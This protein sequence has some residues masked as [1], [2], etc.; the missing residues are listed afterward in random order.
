MW[1]LERGYFTARAAPPCRIYTMPPMSPRRGVPAGH[2]A[3]AAEQLKTSCGRRS[4]CAPARPFQAPS[5]AVPRQISECATKQRVTYT[6][7]YHC[8]PRRPRTPLNGPWK[9]SQLGVAPTQRQRRQSLR[10]GPSAWLPQGP[11]ASAGSLVWSSINTHERAPRVTRCGARCGAAADASSAKRSDHFWL[12]L[13]A[14]PWSHHGALSRPCAPWCA[15]RGR[16]EPTI[17]GN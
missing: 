16:R 3:A 13:A 1:K 8:E 10:K 6:S 5:D 14:P 12:S 11:Q 9:P 4:R 2:G 7:S 17:T 15:P